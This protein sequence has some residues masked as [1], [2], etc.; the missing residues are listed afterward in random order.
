VFNFEGWE[1]KHWELLFSVLVVLLP[2]L[3]RAVPGGD[4][5][6]EAFENIKEIVKKTLAKDTKTKDNP[7]GR[8]NN[9]KEDNHD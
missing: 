9:K 5:W 7:P 4:K 1:P 6:A 3:L 2:V 8:G